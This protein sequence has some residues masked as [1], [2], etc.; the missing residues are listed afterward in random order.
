MSVSSISAATLKHWLRDGSELALIDVREQGDYFH[1]HLLFASCVPFSRLEL[2]IDDLVPRRNVRLVVC[3]GGPADQG[4]AN[5][6]AAIL[7]AHEYSDVTVL[8]QGV[9]G[10]RAAGYE[11]FSGINVP[12][13]AFG[14]IVEQRCGT[15][16]ISAQELHNKLV[17]GEPLVIL[18]SR[19]MNEFQ[20]MSIPGGID[21]PGAELVYRV[22]EL[23]PDA[24]T[25][26]V[27]NCAGRTRSII[28]AQSLRN[29]GLPNPVVA[30]K[31]GT[32]GWALAGLELAHGKT[33]HAPEPSEQGRAIALERAEQVARRCGV[34]WLDSTGL[35][36]WQEEAGQHSLY[37]L[38]VRTPAEYEAGHLPGSRNAP[39][40]QL[41]Q[42]TD[43]YIAT[44]NARVVLI[45]DTYVR[46]LMTA[47]WLLQ[48]GWTDVRVLR[49][50]GFSGMNL[51]S[52]SHQPAVL[53]LRS[54]P[55]LTATQLHACLADE[56][57]VVLD[58]STS[59]VYRQ[60]HIPGA[61]WALRGRLQLV[62]EQ[63][64]AAP[65]TPTRLICTADQDAL[66]H[67]A[68]SDLGE[69]CPRS[70]KLTIA[71]LAGGNAAWQE[72]GYHLSQDDEQFTSEPNEV[73]YK[74]YEHRGAVEQAMRD[75]LTWEVNLVEQIERDGDARFNP[76][77]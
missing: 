59:L 16:H 71:V 22:Q 46:A 29:A 12:S 24:T 43:E 64:Q 55:T 38:D 54:Q 51:V 72:A 17:Q 53:G 77:V 15:P 50:D 36:A 32:M 33:E 65:V 63:L 62:V 47:S 6:A 1:Q 66:A 13:K 5:R 42:A 48:M 39:G 40:G 20:R 67:L 52:G 31:D 10:W 75:Y 11:L 37:L 35:S 70:M 27:V 21:C 49:S 2:L 28:G 73:W 14:E 44:R 3:D 69:L 25:P 23:A 41:V 74:P 4:L 60:G 56:T 7:Q 26:V 57:T 58:F 19:P 68:A 30:L 8:E 18:D 76:L 9:E 34:S 61:W 45:D